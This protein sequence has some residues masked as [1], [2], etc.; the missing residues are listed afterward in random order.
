MSS[1][2]R[3]AQDAKT[4]APSPAVIADADLRARRL[5]YKW[6]AWC[7]LIVSLD[8]EARQAWAEY[9]ALIEEARSLRLALGSNLPPLDFPR[10][11]E[12]ASLRRDEGALKWRPRGSF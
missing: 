10:S 1:N 11:P 2:A 12:M 3:I 4:L 9:G 8:R 6:A 7:E 5:A